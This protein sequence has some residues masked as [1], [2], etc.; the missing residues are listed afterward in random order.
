[1]PKTY[2]GRAYE[3]FNCSEEVMNF[4]FNNMDKKSKELMIKKWGKELDNIG[5]TRE[6]KK[7]DLEPYEKLE[8]EIE[9]DI[10]YIN[11]LLSTGKKLSN[12]LLKYKGYKENRE[13]YTTNVVEDKKSSITDI[14]VTEKALTIEKPIIVKKSPV[15]KAKQAPKK[16]KVQQQKLTVIDYMAKEY[17]CSKEVLL[18]V[19]EELHDKEKQCFKEYY[20]IDNTH[21]DIRLISKDLNIPSTQVEKYIDRSKRYLVKT[22]KRD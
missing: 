18:Q 7:Y 17:N 19:I 21:K 6:L 3:H 11:D 12:I 5:N 14:V 8:K 9:L 15:V 1:M 4:I 13:S 20:G 22:L 10:I 2:N 16:K